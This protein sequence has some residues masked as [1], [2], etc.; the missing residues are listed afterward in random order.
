[1]VAIAAAHL[2]PFY[3][4]Q[5]DKLSLLFLSV[6]LSGVTRVGVGGGRTAPGGTIQKVTP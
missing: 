4:E 1:M 2:R 6:R 3:V 5:T